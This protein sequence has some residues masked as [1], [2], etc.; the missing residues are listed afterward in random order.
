MVRVRKSRKRRT[1]S[2]CGGT[3]Q[4]GELYEDAR[5]PPGGELGN[6]GWWRS[7]SHVGAYP[8]EERT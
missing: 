7:T 6:T 3:I 5:L 2:R 1:C 8:R 4:P